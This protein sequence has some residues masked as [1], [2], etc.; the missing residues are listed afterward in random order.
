MDFKNTVVIM[1]SNIGSP[2]LLEGVTRD[3]L[4]TESARSAVMGELQRHFRPEFLNRVDDS[5]LF[6]SLTKNELPG[7]VELLVQDL[8]RRLADRNVHLQIS[9]NARLFI[10]Q[11]GYDPD[12]GARPLKRYLQRELETKIGKSLI[13]G[14]VVEGSTSVV[15]SDDEMLVVSRRDPHASTAA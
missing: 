10:A 3:G 13:V 1:T 12:Y 4:V 8:R 2:H 5:I 14:E 6:K 9:E 7:I 15:D 11:K